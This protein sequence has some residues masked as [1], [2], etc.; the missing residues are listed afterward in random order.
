MQEDDEDPLLTVMNENGL[1][2]SESFDLFEILSIYRTKLVS[3]KVR[4]SSG[5][6]VTGVS[7]QDTISEEINDVKIYIKLYIIDDDDDDD[8]DLI[9]VSHII[10]P[11]LLQ[12]H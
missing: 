12:I 2:L 6:I 1:L 8:D 11:G 10:F 5:L 4:S 9:L 7:N 3:K